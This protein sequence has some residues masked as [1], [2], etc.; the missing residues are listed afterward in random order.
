MSNSRTVRRTS[1]A[2]LT[3]IL[4]LCAGGVA[5]IAAQTPQVSGRPMTFLDMQQTSSAGSWAPSPDGRWMLYTISTPD[6]QEDERQSDIH[7][8]S[9]EDGVTSSRQLT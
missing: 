1:I 3:A 9:M 6:W 5:Q 7:L 4:G 2:S 8:V